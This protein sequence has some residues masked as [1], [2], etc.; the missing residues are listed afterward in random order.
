MTLPTHIGSRGAGLWAPVVLAAVAWGCSA[1]TRP[2]GAAPS[3]ALLLAE[4][5]QAVSATT[6]YEAVSR[7][8]PEWL[9]RRGQISIQD[10][11]A[12][13]VVV[14]LDGVRYGGPGSLT[15]IRAEMV[16]QMEYLDGNDATT[17]F[18]TGH[19]GGAIL[20]RTR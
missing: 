13:E 16:L 18:G 6:A 10:P 19:A 17:R 1:A 3:R 4:E 9:R 2:T 12:G 20:V 8:R 14:Y 11:S 7:L 5:I 15:S